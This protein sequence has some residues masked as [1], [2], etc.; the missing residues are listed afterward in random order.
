MA[1][2]E[3]ILSRLKSLDILAN[4]PS[5]GGKSRPVSEAILKSTPERL[6]MESSD[7]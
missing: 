5:E 1:T 3:P 4:S 7:L 2:A 6:N